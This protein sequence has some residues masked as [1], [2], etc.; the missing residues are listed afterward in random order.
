M[1]VHQRCTQRWEVLP[2]GLA[3]WVTQDNQSLTT[4]EHDLF[5]E[6]EMTPEERRD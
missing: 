1:G 2:D 5:A 4:D 3:L 6:N